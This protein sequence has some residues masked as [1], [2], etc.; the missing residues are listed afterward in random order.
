VDRLSR[1]SVPRIAILLTLLAYGLFDLLRG[2]PARRRVAAWVAFGSFW[3]LWVRVQVGGVILTP[4]ALLILFVTVSVW[5]AGTGR[6]R[7]RLVGLAVLGLFTLWALVSWA[8]FGGPPAGGEIIVFL[9][10]TMA[11]WPE[12]RPA[13]RAT[14]PARSRRAQK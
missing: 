13:L 9:A 11:I 3:L 5:L 7:S 12:S 8:G 10:A 6:R 14:R 1:L 4:S 2:A